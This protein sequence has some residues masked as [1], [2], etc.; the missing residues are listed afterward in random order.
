MK[1]FN[2]NKSIRE[3]IAMQITTKAIQAELTKW[4]AECTRI[5]SLFWKRHCEK[6][7]K[8]G[9]EQ[10]LWDNLIQLNIVNGVIRTEPELQY[11]YNYGDE[12]AI[13]SKSVKL[14]DNTKHERFF[15][16]VDISKVTG[17]SG[18]FRKSHYSL[19]LVFLN[20]R[21][22][23]N[24]SRSTIIPLN[25][26][27][28]KPITDLAEWFV[29][30]YQA[31]MQFHR[32]TM[33]VLDSCRTSRQLENIFP[34]AAALLP[35]PEQKVVNEVAPIELVSKIQTMLKQGISTTA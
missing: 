29:K 1:S 28:Q 9:L 11:E 30:I 13:R 16:S 12:I 32:Q 15:N 18:F 20:Q 3:N 34:E 2:L 33:S 22:V 35:K 7:V 14:L 5:N 27:L 26:D 25:D 19:E 10:A 21:S 6:V 8:A 4:T 31:A 24:I 23:P 17:L